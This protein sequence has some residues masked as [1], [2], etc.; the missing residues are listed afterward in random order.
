MEAEFNNNKINGNK[1]DETIPKSLISN[2]ELKR[3]FIKLLRKKYEEP[4]WQRRNSGRAQAK[5]NRINYKIQL[6]KAMCERRSIIMVE[7]NIIL[8]TWELMSNNGAY[9]NN[10]VVEPN[11]LEEAVEDVLGEY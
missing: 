8:N 1:S 11:R 10:V 9:Q 4:N 5:F 2:E 7:L 6:I 3:K